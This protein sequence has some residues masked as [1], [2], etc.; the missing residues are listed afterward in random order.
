MNQI[1]LHGGDRT[2]NLIVLSFSNVGSRCC[3]LVFGL[4]CPFPLIALIGLVSRLA[5]HIAHYLGLLNP[6]VSRILIPK[7]LSWLLKF[8]PFAFEPVFVRLH[9]KFNQFRTNRI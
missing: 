7:I 3:R 5:A 2:N 4:D 1:C 9:S 8:L 6:F